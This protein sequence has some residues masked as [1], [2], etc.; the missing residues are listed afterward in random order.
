[1]GQPQFGQ[2][3]PGAGPQPAGPQYGYPNQG[4]AY[5]P[6]QPY[7]S[8][9]GPWPGGGGGQTPPPRSRKP[10]FIGLAAGAVVLVI[11]L[12]ITLV[13]T[14]GGGSG[15]EPDAAVKTYLQ[16][17]SDGDAG[18]ALGVMKA[19]PS[20]LLL[21]DEVLKKQ[22][23]IAKITDIKIVDTNKGGNTATV[24][25]TYNYGDRKA[26]ETFMLKKTGDDWRLDDGAVSVEVSSVSQIP[27]LTA[28]GI[29]VDK[30]AKIYYFPGPMEWGSSDKN[31]T[32]VDDKKGD[33]PMSASAYYG[34]ASLT[35]E[36]SATGQNAVQ[37]AVQGYVDN[38]ALSKQVDASTDKP[39]CGQTAYAYNAE[40]GS[41]TWTAPTDL[42]GL[43]YRIGYDNPEEVSINGQLAWSVT[44]R[45]A[46]T[47]SRPAETKTETDNDF[48]FGKV[49]LA[50][51][52]PT[53]TPDR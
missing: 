1:M 43:D 39:G 7:Q 26:D 53:Y 5:G 16:A 22:Q 38:C 49:D 32:V 44:F 50:E 9:V 13:F 31:F 10:L 8:N 20:D 36:L 37:S 48:L 27:G 12:V 42:S 11:A 33:F 40:P 15:N 47:G 17:L 46:A 18:K 6:Y 23:A 35:T 4:D 41:A 24:Q 21:T 25:A 52:P 30:E 29:A 28:F 51:N 2:V 19:P 34:I 14:L 3:S 45:T